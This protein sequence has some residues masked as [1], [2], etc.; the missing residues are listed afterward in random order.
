M[1]AAIQKIKIEFNEYRDYTQFILLNA[2]LHFSDDLTT[3][4]LHY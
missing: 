4:W 2:H 1:D 3:N